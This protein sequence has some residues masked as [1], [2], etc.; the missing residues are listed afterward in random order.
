MKSRLLKALPKNLLVD[1]DDRLRAEA[2]K[3]FEMV[4]DRSGLDAKRSRELEGQARFRMMEQAFQEVCESADGKLL[5]GGVIPRTDLKVFQPFIRF[6]GAKHGV[7]LGLSAMTE[8]KS[9]P[10]KNKSRLAAVS[11]N[12]YLSP[13]LDLDGASPKVG[14]LFALFLV[15]RDKD[16]AGKIEEVALGVIDS[17]YESF[18]FYEPLETFMAGYTERPQGK[19]PTPRKRVVALKKEIKPFVPPEMPKKEED[20]SGT[21]TA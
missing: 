18:L 17:K 15:S 11:L 6:E 10:S 5:E 7:I 16:R 12:Y 14:D 8:P 21:G 2:L 20:D 9:I 3:A 1:L 4:R 19:A 13:R